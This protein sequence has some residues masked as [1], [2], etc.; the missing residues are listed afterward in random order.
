MKVADIISKRVNKQKVNPK[1]IAVQ[2]IARAKEEANVR[3]S[4][5]NSV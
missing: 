4:H 1:E 5:V 2:R 3:L